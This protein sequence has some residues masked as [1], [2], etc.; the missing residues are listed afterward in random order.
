MAA[1][2][3]YLV[4]HG[5]A[6]PLAKDD[7]TR[8]LSPEGRERFTRLLASL[9]GRLEVSRVLTSPLLRARQTAEIL[10]RATGAKLE[11]DPRLA[12]GETEGRELLS[13]ARAAPHG[14]ALVGHNPE[15]AQALALLSGRELEVKPGAVAAVEVDQSGARLAWLELPTR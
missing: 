3:V 15:L 12:A 6:E 11:E 10:A 4:R 1:H 8:R 5:K 2:R 14:T 7:A 9:A 13:I